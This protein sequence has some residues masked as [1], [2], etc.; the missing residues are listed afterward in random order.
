MV[1][2]NSKSVTLEI[3]GLRAKNAPTKSKQTDNNLF[4]L[5]RGV[6]LL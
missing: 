4:G 5:G 6:H 1:S 2:Q 3:Q